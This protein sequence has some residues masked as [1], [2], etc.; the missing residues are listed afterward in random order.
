ML[1]TAVY[2]DNS[3]AVLPETGYTIFRGTGLTKGQTDVTIQYNDGSGSSNIK[4]YQKITVGQ[5]E[6]HHTHTYAGSPWYQDATSH[7]HQ[8]TDST[9][10]DPS[11]S[12]KDQARHTFVWEVDKA[13]TTTQTG[14]KHEECTV[15]HFKRSKNTVIPVLSD[16]GTPTPGG[17][18]APGTTIP[19]TTGGTT[20]AAKS[21]KTGD[22]GIALYAGLSLLTLSG[23]GWVVGK[24]RREEKK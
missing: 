11:N 2:D 18:A 12:T 5:Y 21:P 8:C 3:K 16:S 4:T 24:K 6:G 22:A 14:L 19:G 20:G 7:W 1:V 15:C 23:G 9:C 10:P 17:T 13:A